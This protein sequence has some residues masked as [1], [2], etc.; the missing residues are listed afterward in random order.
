MS[1]SKLKVYE[2]KRNFTKSGEPKA[3]VK[4]PSKGNIYSIQEHHA[5]SHLHWDL[6]LE[7]EGIL[8]SW[9][10]PKSPDVLKEKG[11]KRLAIQT[12]DHPL[13]YAFFQGEIKE[14]YGK[15][16]VKL[17]DKGTYELK[18]KDSKKIEININGR[19]LK[20]DYVLIKSNYGSKPDKSWLFFKV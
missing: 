11:T 17:W 14:G 15:G 8:L 7:H 12:E 19:K 3:I 18:N 1:T 9:A 2:S 20:G 5:S 4:S 13:D 16:I 6:R 10:I